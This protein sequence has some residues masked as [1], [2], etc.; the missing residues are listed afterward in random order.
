MGEDDHGSAL[1]PS[2]QTVTPIGHV[3]QIEAARVKDVELSPDGKTLAVLSTNRL[4]LYSPEGKLIDHLPITAG[5]LG[6][7]WTPDSRTLFASGDKGQVYHVAE[8]TPDKWSAITSFVVDNLSINPEADKRATDQETETELRPDPDTRYLLKHFE[9]PSPFKGDPQVTGLAVSPDGK[10]LY[11]ALS[12]RNTVTIVDIA[13]ESIIATVPCGV[14]PFRIV[15]SPD[16]KT[17]IVA[18]RGG[19]HPGEKET[20]VARSAGTLLRIDPKTDAALRGSIS[21]INASTFASTEMDEGRQPTGMILSHD[22]KT[23]YVANSDEDTVTTVDVATRHVRQSLSLQPQQDPGLGQLPTDIALAGDERSLYVTCGGGN[24][25]AVV[26]LPQLTL[27]GFLPTAWFPIAIAER[28]GNL[29]VGNSK[30]IGSRERSRKSL[31]HILGVPTIV[32]ENDFHVSGSISEVQ[33]ISANDRADLIKL[34]NQ[35]AANNHWGTPELGPRHGM[36][37]VPVPE[38]VGEPSVFKHIVYIIKENHTYDFDLGDLPQGN[39]DK[40]LCAFGEGFTPNEHALAEQFVL[41]DNTYTSGT[42]SADGHQWADS[43]IANAYIEQNYA[44]YARSYPF[45]GSDPLAYSPNGFLWNAAMHAGKSVRV[46]G[47]FVDKPRITLGGKPVR[48][49]WSQLWNDYKTGAHQYSITA[50]TDNAALRPCLS[51]DYVGFPLVVS[52]QWRADQF[53]ADFKNFER[54]NS[55]PALS[56]LLLPTNHT[57]GTTPGMPKPCSAVADNDLAFG[58]IVDAISHS[59]FWP[60]TLILVVEDDSLFALDHVDG[61]RMISFCISPYTRRHSVVSE[62]YNHTSFVRTIGLVLGLPAMTRFD[63][64]ATPLTACF[65]SEPDLHPYTHLPNRVALDDLNPPLTASHGLSLQ[66]AKASSR[67]DWSAPDRA[68]ATTVARAAW[69]SQRPS[70]FFPWRY[71]HPATGGDDDD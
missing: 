31:F 37:P 8:T 11:V 63:R 55:L 49:T 53:L 21:F 40:N 70:S 41:L 10:R 56:I 13:S 36:M 59:R 1:V 50:S 24:A 33:F 20:N 16:N 15:V 71:F 66:L 43:G 64:T 6:L 57:S 30:G 27:Q 9:K 35:V 4:L 29:F 2:N 3:E 67:L 52:D 23:L 19:S 32:H 58:R 38:R 26:A 44:S 7:A 60:D 17:V 12:K 65:T 54:Q 51:R 69:Q 48:A 18:N 42:N 14:A 46:Y 47:E 68:D 5:P 22:G 34:T 45:N 62:S 25:I 39:G 61:H 28:K